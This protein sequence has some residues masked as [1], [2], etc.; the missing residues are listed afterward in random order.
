MER[1]YQQLEEM[2]TR[3]QKH[4]NAA[5]SRKLTEFRE[6]LVC[7]AHSREYGRWYRAVLVDNLMVRS[8][9]GRMVE[10]CVFVCVW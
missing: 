3:L 10:V 6:G 9:N 1:N 7:V 8:E 2:Q 5:S 4:C